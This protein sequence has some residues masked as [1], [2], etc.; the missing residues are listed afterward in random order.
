MNARTSRSVIEEP[1]RLTW[2]ES[3]LPGA[4]PLFHQLQPVG[5]TQRS[6]STTTPLRS[7]VSMKS[8]AGTSSPS[9][10]SIRSSSS[11]RATR[12]EPSSTIGW[13]WRVSRSASRAARIRAAAL[14]RRS[15]LGRSPPRLEQRH[16]VA[17]ALLRP[18]HGLVGALEHRLGAAVGAAEGRDADAGADRRARPRRGRARRSP[19]AGPRRTAAPPPP[20]TSA[21][22]PR[23]RRRPCGRS[24][25]SREPVPAGVAATRRRT[26]SPAGCPKVSLTR[27]QP[28]D[29]DRQHGAGGPVARVERDRLLEHAPEAAAVD[30]AGERVVVGEVAQA[31]LE[32]PSL[33]DV[34]DLDDAARGPAALGRARARR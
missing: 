15:L 28:V 3:G 4:G 17:A 30:Q 2:I 16:P 1:E 19:R 12:P 25:R 7:A 18:V 22:A 29:V 33:A 11:W 13:L 26:L 24:G 20:L 5:T 21:P 9:S 27:L 10:V 32:A 14:W 34:L 6:S 23:T 31:L 8:P